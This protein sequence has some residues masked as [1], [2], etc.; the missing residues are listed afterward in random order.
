MGQEVGRERARLTAD[1]LPRHPLSG[2]ESVKL[3]LTPNLRATPREATHAGLLYSVLGRGP[4]RGG[5]GARGGRGG[6]NS[7]LSPLREVSIYIY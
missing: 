2:E 1:S 5:E 7:C 4:A 3:T 6:G